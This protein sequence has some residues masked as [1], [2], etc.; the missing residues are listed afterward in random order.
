ME[1]HLLPRLRDRLRQES[2]T[3]RS[4]YAGLWTYLIFVGRKGDDSGGGVEQ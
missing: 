1:A 3:V 2:G 4:A